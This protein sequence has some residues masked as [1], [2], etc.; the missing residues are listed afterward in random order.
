MAIAA[1]Y[2]EARRT[3]E[4]IAVI[5]ND[6]S[7]S[8]ADFARRI[9]AARRYLG[10]Q[11]L[12]AGA[13]AVID[14]RNLLDA[15]TIG[16]ALRDLGLTT[17]VAREGEDI[18]SLG[19]R[20]IGCIVQAASET[21]RAAPRPASGAPCRL[22]RIPADLGLG[23]LQAPVAETPET[24]AQPGGHITMT[25]GTTGA[26]K[27]VVWDAVMQAQA[28]P[29]HAEI[30][31]ISAQSV[32]Y[33]ANLALWTAGGF[34]WPLIAWSMGGTVVIHEVPGL[35][36]PL[37]RSDITHF[38]T[39]PLHLSEILR[40][41]EGELRR[42][43]AMRLLVTGGAMSSAML[44]AAK[45]KLTRQVYSALASTESLTLGVTPVEQPDDLLWHRIHPSREV[46]LVDEAGEV[47][48]PGQE[49]SVR[50]RIVDGIDSYLD[51]EDA[52]REFFRGGYFYPGD[53]GMFGEDGR[54]S[55]RGRMSD[56]I[57]VFG[58]KLATGPIEQA[59]Q[60]RLGVE[61]VCILCLQENGAEDK[62]DVV[63]Q[64]NRP[65]TKE[66][67]ASARKEDMGALRHAAARFRVVSGMPRNE[68]GKVRRLELK[69]QLTLGR[70]K[71]A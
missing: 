28:I 67:L 54:L 18:A 2:A 8:Y 13:V 55:L 16:F 34:G 10:Q 66:E 37:A 7:Y 3:P 58:V 39:T 68:L 29:E 38:F 62:I 60:D 65:L 46:Q 30:N 53:M 31:G 56:V 41:P 45:Q 11:D 35:H 70:S 5:H 1:I 17:F 25:S 19:L 4:K 26:S 59:L 42:N 48:G 51:D 15:W 61:G 50:V 52:S 71:S 49:G 43:D 63:I 14:V 23:D 22:I 36:R 57:N 9:E 40:A 69:R 20:G 47:L 6:V 27:K 44:A 64:S 21:G 33:V 24:A 12:P 32:V